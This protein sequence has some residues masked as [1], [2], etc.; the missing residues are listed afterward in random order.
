MKEGGGGGGSKA[1][2]ALS[3]YL[4][5]TILSAMNLLDS[6]V[7]LLLDHQL[8]GSSS[9]SSYLIA[10]FWPSARALVLAAP[11]AE[12]SHRRSGLWRW[13]PPRRARAGRVVPLRGILYCRASPRPGPA[14]VVSQPSCCSKR[15]GYTS[16]MSANRR[17]IL[18]ARRPS[19]PTGLRSAG[20]ASATYVGLVAWSPLFTSRACADWHV[21]QDE[22]KHQVCSVI[23]TL[24]IQ[25]WRS[26]SAIASIAARTLPACRR[27]WSTR[28]RCYAH[29]PSRLLP[30]H[31]DR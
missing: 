14:G 5:R 11:T 9:P 29:V 20:M 28:R 26:R 8:R 13:T 23:A 25:L 30:R 3:A 15:H 7:C 18:L 1:H 10:F 22:E 27:R 31:G 19:V 21:S 12:W 24:T 6:A 17:P 2:M 4:V 16:L